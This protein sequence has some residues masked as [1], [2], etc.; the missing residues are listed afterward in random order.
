MLQSKMHCSNLVE[1]LK[2]L[3]TVFDYTDLSIKQ[4]RLFRERYSQVLTS[5]HI[6]DYLFIRPN[7]T[8]YSANTKKERSNFA[9]SL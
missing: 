8:K 9:N 3:E 6:F 2:V 5:N 1:S 4:T 7:K